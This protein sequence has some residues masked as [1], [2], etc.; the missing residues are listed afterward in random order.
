MPLIFFQLVSLFVSGVSKLA[1]RQRVEARIE[2][3]TRLLKGDPS[4]SNTSSSFLGG[5]LSAEDDAFLAQ[6]DSYL[7]QP[8]S[9]S[10]PA[11]RPDAS[12]LLWSSGAGTNANDVAVPALFEPVVLIEHSASSEELVRQLLTPPPAVIEPPVTAVAAVEAKGAKG[13]AVAAKD[14]K[15]SKPAKA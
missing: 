7:Q 8:P 10:V 9:T 5:P 15:P 14:A 6:L 1:V 13:K 4:Q 12:E 2:A 11:G 3:A